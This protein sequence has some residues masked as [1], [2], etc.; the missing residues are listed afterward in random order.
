MTKKIYLVDL[1]HRAAKNAPTPDHVAVQPMTL[2][3]DARMGLFQHPTSTIEF[4]PINIGAKP[5]LSFACGLKQF[6]WE[7]VTTPIIF[8]IR[9]RDTSGRESSVFSFT[10]NPRQEP[11]HRKWVEQKI[12]LSA[13]AETSATIILSTSVPAQAATDY[14]W[15]GWADLCLTHDVPEKPRRVAKAP[16]PH[17]FL[18]TADALRAD[19]LGCYGNPEVKTPQLDQLAR[20]GIQLNHARVQTSVTLG[21]YATL[22]TGRHLPAHQVLAEWGRFPSHMLGLPTYLQGQGY[23]TMVATSEAELGEPGP[24]VTNLFAEQIPCLARPAQ[25]GSITSRQFIKWLDTIPDCPTFAWLQFFDTHPP[26]MP[27]E[28]FKSQYYPGDPAAAHNAFDQEALSKVRGIEVVQEIM[29]ALPL[30]RQGTV[31]DALRLRLKSTVLY[32]Q[33][34]IPCGPDLASHLV[35]LGT[36]AWGNK[37]HAGFTSWLAEQVQCLDNDQIPPALLAWLEKLLPTLRE[38]EGDIL[39]WLDGVV[40]YRF[41]VNQ[42]KASVSYLD[43]LV[44]EVIAELKHRGLYESSTIIFTSPHGELFGE[45]GVYFHH[46]LL[47]EAV[48][49]VPM[50]IKPGNG[51][52]WQGAQPQPGSRIDGIFDSLD[53]FPTLIDALGFPIPRSLDGVSRWPQMVLNQPIPP[54]ESISIDQHELAYSVLAGQFKYLEVTGNHELSPEWNWKRGE[55]AL[56][57]L[58]GATGE[59]EDVLHR[60][61]QIAAELQKRLAEWRR[62]FTYT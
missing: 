7:R 8:G 12:E 30:M 6:S 38:I 4:E 55:R 56:F 54:H 46:H 34:K 57:D 44:G 33:G 62:Q 39:S 61:P 15:A 20:A 52:A 16:Q 31:D 51:C 42:H 37:S 13:F 28:P 43:H 3:R 53:L 1:L 45:R 41:P 36:S 58:S 50:I 11:G 40:D 29:T 21:S 17:V 10:L 27:P 49:R 26:Q 60:H 14:C 2:N 48:L 18:I 19:L 25:D 32:F 47:L 9:L 5:S 24:G 22:L 35:S 23:H 59:N